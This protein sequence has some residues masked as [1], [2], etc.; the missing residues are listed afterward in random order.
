L[1]YI[2]STKS[3]SVLLKDLYFAN[4]VALSKNEDFLLVNETYRYRIKRY[5]LKG[6]K[7]GTSDIFI[8]NLPG[9]PDGVSA[10]RKGVFWVALFTVRND[11]MDRLHPYPFLKGLLSKMPRKYWPKPVPYGLV[12]ALDEEGRITQSLHEP[13]G[14]HLHEITSVEEHQGFLYLGSLHNDRIGRFKLH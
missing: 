13:T 5:W 6:P 1:R 10:N 2:P 12:L 7:V 14:K 11:I 3:V 9:F 8:D 4:G